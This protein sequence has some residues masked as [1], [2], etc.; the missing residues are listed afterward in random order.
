MKINIVPFLLAFLLA[1]PVWKKQ[2]NTKTI[3]P[4]RVI[5]VISTMKGPLNTMFKECVGAGRATKGYVPMQQKWSMS[6]KRVISNYRMHGLANRCYG[7]LQEDDKKNRSITTVYLK[8]VRLPVVIGIK[9]LSNWAFMPSW[10]A[11]GNKTIFWWKGNVSP[12]RITA[13]WD[14]FIRI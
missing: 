7:C 9:L 3:V 5:N 12:P 13:K 14:A 10:L 4:E 6:K 11:S 2:T 8:L 1:G